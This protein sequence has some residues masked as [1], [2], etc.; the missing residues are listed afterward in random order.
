LCCGFFYRRGRNPHTTN[1][2]NPLVAI[3]SPTETSKVEIG[4]R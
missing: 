4:D 1:K 3:R 2:M